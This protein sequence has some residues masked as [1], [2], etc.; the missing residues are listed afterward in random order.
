MGG[1]LNKLHFRG[2]LKEDVNVGDADNPV[3]IVVTVRSNKGR[4]GAIA[5]GMWVR[6]TAHGVPVPHANTASG[7]TPGD[8]NDSCAD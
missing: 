7:R 6:E 1:L 5:G 8:K 3:T 4:M 2:F